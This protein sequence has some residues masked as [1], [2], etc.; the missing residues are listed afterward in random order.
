[1]RQRE[2]KL[3]L[4]LWKVLLLSQ[5]RA[6]LL[7]QEELLWVRK[8]IQTKILYSKRKRTP[9][10]LSNMTQMQIVSFINLNNFYRKKP[11][12]SEKINCFP[13][14]LIWRRRRQKWKWIGHGHGWLWWILQRQKLFEYRN[15]QIRPKLRSKGCLSRFWSKCSRHPIVP[16]QSKLHHFFDLFSSEHELI[17]TGSS[18]QRSSG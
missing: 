8:K 11:I 2:E 16:E 18:R 15:G 7:W 9:A 13:K 5:K 14:F 1:M 6:A 10:W 4:I 12:Y 3:V 17:I